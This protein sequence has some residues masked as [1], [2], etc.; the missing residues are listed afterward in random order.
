MHT[1]ESAPPAHRAFSPTA[2]AG[3]H[4]CITGG[5]GAIGVGVVAALSAHGAVVSVNDIV[6]EADAA[7]RFAAAHIDPARVV[8][9]QADTTTKAAADAFL[10]AAIGR[11]G[12]VHTAL[13]HAGMVLSAPILDY[14]PEA[15]DRLMDLN[16]KAAFLLGQSAARHM[17]AAGTHGLLLFTTSWVAETPWPEIGI[18]NTSKAGMNQ[19]MRSFARELAPHGIR[20]NAVAP[21]IVGV[22]MA[23]RQW[24]TEPAYRARAEKAIPLGYMQPLES[25]AD[26]F[27]FACSAAARYMTGTVLLVDGGCS[28]YPMD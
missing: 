20:A 12:P 9:V 28:L 4:V 18:Y 14:T 10:D 2:L 17:I 1:P 22:G 21:G 26:A 15:W 6:S 16:L 27:V 11:F 13:L 23:K 19:L 7:A 24:D 25:V 3:Q 5:A 8:Y